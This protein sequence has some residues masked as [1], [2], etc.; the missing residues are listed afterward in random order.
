[1]PP[2]CRPATL[3]RL[4]PAPANRETSECFAGPRPGCSFPPSFHCTQS[5]QP[6]R[7]TRRGPCSTALSFSW[8]LPCT[9]MPTVSDSSLLC[10]VISDHTSH[11]HPGRQAASPRASLQD[12]ERHPAPASLPRALRG[13]QGLR[14]CSTSSPPEPLQAVSKACAPAVCRTRR[15]GS[16]LTACSISLQTGSPV[17]SSRVQFRLR[18][19]CQ[20]IRGRQRQKPRLLP[21]DRTPCA[22]APRPSLPALNAGPTLFRSLD[23]PPAGKTQKGRFG[24]NC[25]R[26]LRP[27]QREKPYPL[28]R[29]PQRLWDGRWRDCTAARTIETLERQDCRCPTE[30]P[31]RHRS[32]SL[33]E[34]SRTAARKDGGTGGCVRKARQSLCAAGN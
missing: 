16:C 21:S 11:C 7:L 33:S 2:H 4:P 24:Q 34:S 6:I 19:A 28:F 22:T 8:P 9:A 31:Q 13:T 1:M 32:N 3:R 20:D 17:S 12:A 27:C 18:P 5:E 23:C 15:K 26:S 30:P 25:P 29:P 10:S 14:P